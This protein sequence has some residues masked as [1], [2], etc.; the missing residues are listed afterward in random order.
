MIA[1]YRL[2]A[3]RWNI[4][5]KLYILQVSPWMQINRGRTKRHAGFK[6]GCGRET[7]KFVQ[8]YSRVE[9]LLEVTNSKQISVKFKLEL[10]MMT[11]QSKTNA[12]QHEAPLQCRI[13]SPCWCN[14]KETPTWWLI[15]WKWTKTLRITMI[16]TSVL[17]TVNIKKIYRDWKYHVTFYLW[18]LVQGQSI[19]NFLLVRF[20]Y[21]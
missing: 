13:H 6:T 2:C 19:Q 21:G 20:Q 9:I 10:Q 1:S 5:G 18:P 12:R 3:R 14:Y 15:G 11:L 4:R 16:L 7:W 17:C 8:W